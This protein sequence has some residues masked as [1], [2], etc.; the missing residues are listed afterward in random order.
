MWTMDEMY[1]VFNMGIGMVV[2]CAPENAAELRRQVPELMEIGKIIPQ[3]GD[4]RVT[5]E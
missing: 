1:H 5:I 4:A 2:V 3:S